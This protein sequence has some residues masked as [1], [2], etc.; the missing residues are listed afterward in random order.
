MSA[1]LGMEKWHAYLGS[2]DSEKLSELLADDVVFYSPLVHTPQEGKEITM[3]Y[4]NSAGKVLGDENFEY[5]RQ[6]VDGDTA[7]LEFTNEIEGIKINGID[8]IRF[9]DEGKIVDFKVMV[10]PLKAIQKVHQKMGEMLQ[11]LAN[12]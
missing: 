6:V 1:E 10:R 7:V 4:L 9:N 11:K 8:M 2:H 5:V 3:L 12:Q